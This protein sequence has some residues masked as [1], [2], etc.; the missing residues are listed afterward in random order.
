MTFGEKLSTLRKKANLT[1]KD[2]ANMLGV[3]RQAV[4]KW[5]SGIGIPDIDN[6]KRIASIFNISID[7]LLDYKV[8]EI[9]LKQDTVTEKLEGEEAKLR[10]AE[11]ILLK[12][13]A[14]ADNIVRLVRERQLPLWQSLLALIVGPGIFSTADMLATGLVLPY[15]VRQGESDYLVLISKGT[16]M[17]KKLKESFDDKSMDIDGYKYTKAKLLKSKR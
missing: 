5:E 4:T 14:D 15:F 11:D 2:L 3:S 6:V 10:N 9:E 1:Q 13:F 17:I 12:R 8:E 16:M 7:E